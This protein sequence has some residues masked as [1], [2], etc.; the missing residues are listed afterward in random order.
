MKIEF[1]RKSEDLEALHHEWNALLE[2]AVTQ[3]PFQRHEYQTVW[4]STKGGGEWDSAELWVAVGRSDSGE[5]LAIAP[6]FFTTPSD[7]SPSVLFIGS[8]EI[9]DYL[10]VI[11][12]D[13]HLDEFVASLLDVLDH[14]G[15]KTW[16]LLDLFNLPDDSP[17]KQA[18]KTAAGE[19]GWQVEEQRL[20][21]CP[22]VY[23]P[24]S[25]DAYLDQLDSKQAR[26]LRRK[27]RKAQGY[28]ASVDWHIIS[29]KSELSDAVDTFLALM[30][31][32]SN[33]D[34]F[35]TDPMRIQFHKMCEAAYEH[36]WLQM[37]F[38]NVSNE[39]AFGYVNFDFGNRIW[40]YNSGFDPAHFDL[41]PGWVLMGHLI[42]WAIEEGREAVDFLR[43]DESYKYRLGGHDRFVNRLKIRR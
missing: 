27:L 4:W 6:L 43:G 12:A 16:E 7:R 18:F 31:N 34:E 13:E 29:E 23:L 37:A 10:D 41:S 33:K 15:P 9:S 26:E 3:T 2:T 20:Q 21:P 42:Q 24:D 32:D 40:V 22:I 30:A 17:S 38:L 28:P 14:K 35:L 5:M 11:A 39:P 8:V 1:I 25:W 19:R 36:G